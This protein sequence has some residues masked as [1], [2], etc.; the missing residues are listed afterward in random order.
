MKPDDVKEALRL[1]NSI[2]SEANHLT[3]MFYYIDTDD[4]FK[5]EELVKN[6]K[7]R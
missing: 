5:L 4:D 3:S 6:Y 2:Q 1:A 7:N